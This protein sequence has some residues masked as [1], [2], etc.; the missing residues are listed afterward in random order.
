MSASIVTSYNGFTHLQL[1]SS[2]S[3]AECGFSYSTTTIPSLRSEVE[4]LQA[5]E[6]QTKPS[7][8][9]EMISCGK[10]KQTKSY[11]KLD[12]AIKENHIS[13]LLGTPRKQELTEA[14]NAL[15]QVQAKR[16]EVGEF[17]KTFGD[18]HFEIT[19]KCKKKFDAQASVIFMMIER[20]IENS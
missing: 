18:G 12:L 5:D 15:A 19:I 13:W 14:V 2:G 11:Q 6:I 20:L 10:C 1:D 17:T 3:R 4:E 9:E 8:L 7:A 16:E